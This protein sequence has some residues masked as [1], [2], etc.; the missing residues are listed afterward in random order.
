MSEPRK[1]IAFDVM[2][3]LLYDPWRE[4]LRAATGLPAEEVVHRRDPSIWTRLEQGQISEDTYWD[5]LREL[6][7]P[8]DP[9]LFHQVRRAGYSWLPGMQDLLR[10]LIA[11][12]HQ[13]VLATNYPVWY[14]ELQAGLLAEVPAPVYASCS[15]GAC[16]PDAAYFEH[17]LADRNMAYDSLV[18]IDDTPVNATA[19]SKFGGTGIV[20]VN[21]T[22]TKSQLTKLRYL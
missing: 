3:T 12:G 9:Q 22:E 15:I 4:A 11:R 2:D 14:K 5:H 21:A 19:V 1:L 7:L 16:K 8:V 10:Q 17:I 6:K 13:V 20:H 18:L